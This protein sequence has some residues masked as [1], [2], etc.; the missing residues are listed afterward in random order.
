MY[1]HYL[2]YFEDWGTR[3]I[4][5]LLSLHQKSIEEILIQYIVFIRDKG[6]SY[7]TTK[8]RLAAVVSFLEINDVTVNHKKLKKFMGEH[9]KTIKDEAYSRAD[10]IKMFEHASFRTR[11]LI[12]I[13]SSTGIRKAALIE[14]R[15]RHLRRIDNVYQFTIY[16]NTKDEYITFCT[17]ECASLIDSYIEQRK[18]VGE[19]I[20]DESFLLRNDFGFRG[21][22]ATAR[23][24][25]P[26]TSASLDTV[27]QTLLEKTNMYKVNHETENY[28]YQRHKKAT[29]HGFRK[30]FNTCLVNAD[31]NVTIKEILMGHSVGLDDSYFRPTEKQLLTEYLKA[32]NEL[33]INEENRLRTRVAKLEVE[34]SQIEALAYE[35]EQV[36]KA[37]TLK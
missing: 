11:L 7:S 26:V 5:D 15:L 25:K 21:G 32:V 34:K 36:K 28:K 9:N 22:Q 3:K 1:I 33:T 14:I 35:L 6:L 13:Y 31:V 30:Y 16:E 17:P 12:V 37:I 20:T 23:K 19:K 29:F 27:M 2:R 18:Q 10:L 4:E 24:P 8:C